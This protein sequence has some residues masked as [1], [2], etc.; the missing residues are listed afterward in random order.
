MA[1]LRLPT[2]GLGPPIFSLLKNISFFVI[3]QET[4]TE[5]HELICNS[6]LALSYEMYLIASPC[7]FIN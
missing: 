5:A 3:F 7:R 6:D 4:Y 2:C 1:P